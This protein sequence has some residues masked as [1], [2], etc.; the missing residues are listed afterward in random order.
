VNL[1]HPSGVSAELKGT[2]IYQN[3]DFERQGA[4][5][6]FRAADDSF[7]LVDAALGYRLPKRYGQLTA[8]VRNLFD[9][10]GFEYLDTDERNPRIQPDRTVFIQLTLAFP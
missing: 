4:T 1:F 6:T 2:H 9:T 5:G 8:G 7:F 10:E 3:G